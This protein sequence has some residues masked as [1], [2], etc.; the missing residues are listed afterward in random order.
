MGI[1]P[2]G[3]TEIGERAFEDCTGLTSIV[4]PDSVTKIEERAFYGCKGLTSIVIPD[5]VTSIDYAAFKDCTGLTSVVLPASLKYINDLAFNEHGD[6]YVSPIFE[7]CTALKAIYVPVGKT[8][9]FKELLPEHLH[10]L[11]VEQ[12]II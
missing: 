5:S 8:D 3:E 11:I 1:I 4:I 10:A 7:G 9:Y 2:E 12:Q 6:D